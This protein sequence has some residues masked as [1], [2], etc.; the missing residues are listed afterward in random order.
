VQSSTCGT[1][2]VSACSSENM[3]KSIGH[4]YRVGFAILMWIALIVLQFSVQTSRIVLFS[5]A[6]LTGSFSIFTFV[7]WL[8]DR[9]RAK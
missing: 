4:M 6:L 2:R 3:N 8:T 7:I 1:P 5:A 9:R